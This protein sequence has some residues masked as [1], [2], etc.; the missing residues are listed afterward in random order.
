M[1]RVM[2]VPDDVR[3]EVQAA[4]R[5]LDQT[6]GE[7]LRQAW[8]VYRQTPEFHEDFAF[9]QKAFAGGDL[10]AIAARLEE[11]AQERAS[12]RAG[13]VRGARARS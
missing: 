2:R 13:A 5:L 10:T 12:R 11:R 1:S 9:A 8:E 3:S 7:L 6:P 4:A